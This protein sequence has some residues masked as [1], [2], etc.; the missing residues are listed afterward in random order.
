MMKRFFL[1][2]LAVSLSGILSSFAADKT[3]RAVQ[4]RL[5]HERFYF[6]KVDGVYSSETAVAVSRYQIRHGLQING[7]IDP[8]TANALGVK[9]S[10]EPM[11]APPAA[12]ETWR[13]LRKSD[14][15]FLAKQRRKKEPPTANPLVVDPNTRTLVLSRERLRDYVA[16]FVLAGL[17]PQVGAELEFFGDEVDYFDDGTMERE[18]IR[19]DLEKY[20]RRWPERRFWLAGEVNVEPQPDSLLRVTFPLRFELLNGSKYATGEVMKTLIVEVVGEDLNIVGVKEQRT[21]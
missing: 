11:P 4:K 21:K 20:N 10:A 18:K 19:S 17:D 7:R 16:A 6:G 3:V 9:L 2:L 13:Q 15:Q 8:E 5:K 1:C 12:A 14:P